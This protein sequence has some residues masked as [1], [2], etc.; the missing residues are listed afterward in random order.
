MQMRLKAVRETISAYK[1]YKYINIFKYINTM[2]PLRVL[3]FIPI[4][5]EMI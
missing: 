2:G 5:Y 1:I 3:L 4:V